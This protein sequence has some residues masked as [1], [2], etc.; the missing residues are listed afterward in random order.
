MTRPRTVF[1]D[2]DGT[3]IDHT[4]HLRPSVLEAVQGAR[5]AGHLL[6]VCTGRSR[7]EIPQAISDIGFD[8][9]ISAGGGFIEHGDRLVAAHT[10]SATEAQDVIDFFE[11]HSVEY[12]LQAFES[13]YPSQGL[14]PRLMPFFE[15]FGMDPA[16]GDR[17][18]EAMTYRGPA[19][20]DGIAKAT[21]FGTDPRT[22]ATV[23]D[24]L[25]S[26]F[27]VITGTIP[28]LGEAG[29]EASLGGIHKGAAIEELLA[30]LGLDLADSIAIGDSSNDLEM[31]QVAGVGIAMGNADAAVKAVADEVTTRVDDDGVWNAFRRHGLV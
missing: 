22:F 14:L 9:V 26:R 16:R 2:V 5:S 6:Y 7:V 31:L 13:T 4:Q 29:G 20:L 10:M 18:V 19:P 23:R 8:G 3:L 24:G 30:T 25:G 21:F 1:L 12:T 28:Y 11:Q 27:H 15:S 17:L